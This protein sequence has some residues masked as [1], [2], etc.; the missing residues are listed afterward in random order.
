MKEENLAQGLVGAWLGYLAR[1]WQV[2]ASV[3]LEHKV[4]FAIALAV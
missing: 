3:L 2:Q 4:L 1:H